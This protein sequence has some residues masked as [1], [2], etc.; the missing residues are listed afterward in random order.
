MLGMRNNRRAA[1]EVLGVHCGIVLQ[2]CL[3]EGGLEGTQGAVRRAQ[4]ISRCLQEI[5]QLFSACGLP[6]Q[7]VFAHRCRCA[8]VPDRKLAISTGIREHLRNL[9][10]RISRADEPDGC[11]LCRTWF[12][13]AGRN[14]PDE[15]PVRHSQFLLAIHAIQSPDAPFESYRKLPL[16]SV[17]FR[18]CLN[19]H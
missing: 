11:P 4:S 8:S 12:I 14:N 16:S 19:A 6:G 10:I 3:S 18:P 13:P 7:G 1:E 15:R 5:V 17:R 9:E 2:W